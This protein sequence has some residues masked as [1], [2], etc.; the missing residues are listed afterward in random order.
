MHQSPAPM[1]PVP[2]QLT[3][4]PSEQQQ[5]QMYHQT[6]LQ[7][8]QQAPMNT[9][10]GRAS[11]DAPFNAS[12]SPPVPVTPSPEK[13]PRSRSK[14]PSVDSQS[15][16]VEPQQTLAMVEN[17]INQMLDAP[18]V[19]APVV[20]VNTDD[21]LEVN[22]SV[23]KSHDDEQ[24]ELEKE[25]GR[26]GGGE[27]ESRS[28]SVGSSSAKSESVIKEIPLSGER[29][30]LSR[31]KSPKS[32]WHHSPSPQ[33]DPA[34]IHPPATSDEEHLATNGDEK[35][36]RA[37]RHCPRLPFFV[38]RTPHEQTEK[39]ST[40]TP[41]AEE[42]IENEQVG[43]SAPLT[44]LTCFFSVEWTNS[45]QTARNDRL[46][47]R[48]TSS[49]RVG[50]SSAATETESLSNVVL[51]TDERSQSIDDQQSNESVFWCSQ[52]TLIS[53]FLSF[54]DPHRS[55]PSRRSFLTSVSPL[56]L[57]SIMNWTPQR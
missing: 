6:L 35:Y 24:K 46:S 52:S 25:G 14:K 51:V 7:S 32:R 12:I 5:Q 45:S 2:Q 49:S 39:S 9:R 19:P 42:K 20:A 50:S 15:Y 37:T 28:P 30:R 8:P 29:H 18:V 11:T 33:E 31:S 44:N 47:R 36:V 10:R 22:P 4:S 26:G 57:I 41:L 43:R 23:S 16:E 3:I 56:N 38:I 21:K 55:F 54:A 34:Q 53:F 1:I 40:V 17:S 27:G 48:A 13:K